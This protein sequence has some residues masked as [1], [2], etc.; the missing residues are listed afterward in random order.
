MHLLNYNYTCVIIINNPIILIN[1]IKLNIYQS[2]SFKTKHDYAEHCWQF[3][4]FSI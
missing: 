2:N 4:P 3:R 1:V